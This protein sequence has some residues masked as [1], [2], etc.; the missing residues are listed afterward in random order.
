[1][2]GWKDGINSTAKFP[3]SRKVSI[4]N[5]LPKDVLCNE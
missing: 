2:C 4:V 1:M 3:E 5:K